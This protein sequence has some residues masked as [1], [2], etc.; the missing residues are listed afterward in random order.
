MLKFITIKRVLA[1]A[2]ED[3]TEKTHMVF[4]D[5]SG[6]HCFLGGIG[7]VAQMKGYKDIRGKA[8]NLLDRATVPWKDLPKAVRSEIIA[9]DYGVKDLRK[10]GVPAGYAALL[11]NDYTDMSKAD[12]ATFIESRLTE[13]DL[14]R[15]VPA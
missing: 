10:S 6:S 7:Y 9:T 14:R 5:S 8:W 1:W 2:K 15:R 12:I 13:Q 3:K 11:M 4:E